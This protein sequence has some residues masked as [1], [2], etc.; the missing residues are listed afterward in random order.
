MTMI[1]KEQFLIEHNRLSPSNLQVTLFLLN[2]FK[3]EKRPLLKDNAWV[4][5]KIRIPLISWLLSLTPAKKK[6]HKKEKNE[7][8]FKSYPD[9]K[10]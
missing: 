8:V 3:E 4:V 7:R 1:N 10:F 2:R 6:D 9:T 5:D